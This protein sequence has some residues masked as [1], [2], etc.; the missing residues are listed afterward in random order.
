MA[1]HKFALKDNVDGNWISIQVK[2]FEIRSDNFIMLGEQLIKLH[3]LI[4]IKITFL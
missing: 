1:L 3:K 4:N 2:V